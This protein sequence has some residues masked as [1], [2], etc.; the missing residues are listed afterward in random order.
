MDT[1]VS[2]IN[3]RPVDGGTVTRKRVDMSGQGDFREAWMTVEHFEPS[4]R[5][6]K[7]ATTVLDRHARFLNGTRL[8]EDTS[9]GVLLKTGRDGKS[10]VLEGASMRLPGEVPGLA[11]SQTRFNAPVVIQDSSRTQR[12]WQGVYRTFGESLGPR[13]ELEDARYPGARFEVFDD[14]HRDGGI[15]GDAAFPSQSRNPLGW[16][17]G[18]GMLHQGIR[19][20]GQ[21]DIHVVRPAQ[22]RHPES[23]VTVQPFV[24]IRELQLF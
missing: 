11:T 4:D 6:G 22:G 21:G 10:H 3:S 15:Q 24:S 23:E 9:A 8:D 5:H 17:L 12:I 20:D 14:H 7:E 16:L 19:W 2:I 1:N 18:D 13:F